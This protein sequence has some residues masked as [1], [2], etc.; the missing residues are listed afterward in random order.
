MY[1]LF[2]GSWLPGSRARPPATSSQTKCTHRQSTGIIITTTTIIIIIIIII[3]MM[4]III[5][6][7]IIIHLGNQQATACH[8]SSSN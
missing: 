1:S 3:I 5:I 4:I 8:G 6:I 2:V 7:I